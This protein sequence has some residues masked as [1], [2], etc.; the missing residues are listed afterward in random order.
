MDKPSYTISARIKFAQMKKPLKKIM[1]LLPFSG[2]DP[3]AEPI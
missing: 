2:C 1:V 3:A